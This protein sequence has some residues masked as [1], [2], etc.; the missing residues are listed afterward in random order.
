MNNDTHPGAQFNEQFHS[1]VKSELARLSA[2]DNLQTAQAKALKRSQLSKQS[3]TKDVKSTALAFAM[4]DPPKHEPSRHEQPKPAQTKVE[5]GQQQK[6][7]AVFAPPAKPLPA[8][9]DEPRPQPAFGD[10]FLTSANAGNLVVQRT[11]TISDMNEYVK[12]SYRNPQTADL[13][14]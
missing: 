12:R 5:P 14:R 13:I 6:A 7:P 8:F 11:L 3:P 10:A 4:T 2:Q 9:A 1:V